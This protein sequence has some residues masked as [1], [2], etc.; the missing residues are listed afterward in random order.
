M[1]RPT[2]VYYTE[3][4]RPGVVQLAHE[5]GWTEEMADWTWNPQTTLL[6]IW[7]GRVVGFV[8]GWL[9]GQPV[10][11]IDALVVTPSMRESGIGVALWRAIVD[12]LLDLGAKRVRFLVGNPRLRD[13][14][15][16]EGFSIVNEGA[17]ME[18]RR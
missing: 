18:G 12:H 14:L 2:I 11:M 9:G 8:A 7:K 17:L 15:G 13:M 6:A 1:I 4:W 16:R 3:D 5:V 10:G